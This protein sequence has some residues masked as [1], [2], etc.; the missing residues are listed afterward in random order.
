[1]AGG[2]FREDSNVNEVE[3]PPFVLKDLPQVSS[4][5]AM[6]KSLNMFYQLNQRAM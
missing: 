4:K 6:T 3:L 1:M 5:V 2:F